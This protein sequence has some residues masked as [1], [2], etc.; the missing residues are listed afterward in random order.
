M[1]ATLKRRVDV[2]DSAA[3]VPSFP[4]LAS[5]S[6]TPFDSPAVSLQLHLE[7]RLLESFPDP[8]VQK[9][10]PAW[11]LSLLLTGSVGLWFG[12]INLARL[13]CRWL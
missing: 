10:P 1:S 3:V 8:Y 6:S 2:R 5:S 4:R 9:L 12:L 11:S 7:Q 13:A